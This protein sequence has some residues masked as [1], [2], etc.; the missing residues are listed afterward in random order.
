[1]ERKQVFIFGYTYCIFESAMA[2]MSIH[3]TKI[4]AYKAMRKFLMEEYSKWYDM[5]I[6]IGKKYDKIDKY[7]THCAW[8]VYPEQLNP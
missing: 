3:Q 2:A 7:G 1:M 5:R 6:E 8:T 4:G